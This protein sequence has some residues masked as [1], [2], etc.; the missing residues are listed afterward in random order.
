[1]YIVRALNTF[2]PNTLGVFFFPIVH[3]SI[4]F[5]KI[6]FLPERN[7]SVEFLETWEF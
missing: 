7:T 2:C 1:M 3:S 4:G 5:I 6:V